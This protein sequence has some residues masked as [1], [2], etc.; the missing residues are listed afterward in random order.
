MRKKYIFCAVLMGLFACAVSAVE[1]TGTISVNETS[2][3]AA[4]A[5]NKAFDYA[6]RTVI[7]RELRPYANNEQLDAAIKDSSN[8]DL[9]NIIS[10][11]SLDSEKISDTTYSA[12]ISFVIDGDAAKA[13]M[14]KNSVQNWLPGGF[15]TDVVPVPVNSV[16]VYA[17]LLQPMSDWMN[18]N[19]LLRSVRT[20]LMPLSI[21]GNR[22]TF[23]V[24]DKNISKLTSVL[25][26]GGWHV[27]SV[28][29]GIKIWK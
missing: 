11:S 25:R 3:T 18:L 26:S 6:Q 29:G 19:A 27:Q 23:S 12:N 15:G 21:N 17:T 9:M 20:D 4:Q 8:D 14:D 22:V 28:D 5:K 1:L 10:S 2:D 13:W 16:V 24:P 7:V